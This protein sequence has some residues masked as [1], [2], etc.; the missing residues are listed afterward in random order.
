MGS[1]YTVLG[2]IPNPLTLAIQEWLQKVKR[3]LRL[4]Q[5]PFQ[6]PATYYVSNNGDDSAA[7]TTPQTAWAT[8]AKVQTFLTALSNAN[9]AGGY[10]FLFERDGVFR[11]STNYAINTNSIVFG[12]Y[13]AGADPILSWFTKQ[14]PAGTT[15]TATGSGSWYTTEASVIAAVRYAGTWSMGEIVL[16][17]AYSG[18]DCDATPNSF[19]S[20]ANGALSVNLNGILPT[21]VNLEGVPTQSQDGI[22]VNNVDGFRIQDIWRYGGGCSSNQVSPIYHVYGTHFA[23]NAPN[24]AVSLRGGEVYTGYHALGAAASGNGGICSFFD[25]IVGPVKD[26]DGGGCSSW[27]QYSDNGG[28]EIFVDGLEIQA[29]GIPVAPSIQL[30]GVALVNHSTTITCSDTTGLSP[31]MVLVGAHIPIGATVVSVNVDGIH[32]VISAAVTGSTAAGVYNACDTSHVDTLY[33]FIQHSGTPTPGLNGKPPDLIIESRVWVRSSPYAPSQWQTYGTPAAQKQYVALTGVVFAGGVNISCDST[34]GISAGMFVEGSGFGSNTQIASVTSGTTFHVSTAPTGSAAGT[35]NAVFWSDQVAVTLASVVLNSTTLVTCAS[36]SGLIVGMFLKGTG[37]PLGATIVRITS[38]TT[39]LISNAA[40]TSSASGTYT[41]NIF[42]L[43]YER[44]FIFDRRYGD[45]A[46]NPIATTATSTQLPIADNFNANF[47]GYIVIDSTGSG[48]ICGALQNGWAVNPTLWIDC[49]GAGSGFAIL[50]GNTSG[51]EN[52]KIWN[53]YAQF[54]FIPTDSGAYDFGWTRIGAPGTLG[55]AYLDQ[56]KDSIYAGGGPPAGST[57]RG[58]YTNLNNNLSPAAAA[59]VPPPMQ[60]NAY[61]AIAFPFNGP[62]GISDYNNDPNLIPLSVNLLT[63]SLASTTVTCSTTAGIAIGA[64]VY[65]AGIPTGATV[66]AVTSATTFTI[67]AAT[68]GG[69]SGQYMVGTAKPEPG[70]YLGY[71]GSRLAST[72]AAPPLVEYDANWS[73]RTS[74]TTRWVGPLIPAGD[75]LLRQQQWASETAI[76]DNQGWSLPQ[77]SGGGGSSIPPTVINPPLPLI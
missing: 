28:G 49:S 64:F 76:L 12:A 33:P 69:A 13:G 17:Q 46:E 7:G 23:Q 65:G 21:T 52:A 67:S 3:W 37:V 41:T 74:V 50:G 42:H 32:F 77:A 2:T 10:A 55:S 24:A 5:C 29:G 8:G 35:Y 26:P 48:T 53:G 15:W 57:A 72:V 60:G 1:P 54:D 16:T 66:V 18:P 40:T 34:A 70:N 30:T 22:R 44:T 4:A 25:M 47:R 14:Y 39:F 68:S 6:Q 43:P 58:P 36:T 20:D 63:V 27:V 11:E 75:G 73:D 45:S 61:W 71:L 59:I 62:G 56:L 31:G 38:A 9:S 51:D 19:F